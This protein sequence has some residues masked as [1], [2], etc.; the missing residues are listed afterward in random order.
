MVVSTKLEPKPK[1]NLPIK[2]KEG[3]TFFT[4]QLRNTPQWYKTW[5]R[6]RLKSHLPYVLRGC[7][8]KL[9]Q[10]GFIKRNRTAAEKG[11]SKNS[12][13]IPSG[14]PMVSVKGLNASETKD[15]RHWHEITP[16]SHQRKQRRKDILY[17]N[18]P[19][20]HPSVKHQIHP[21]DEPNR[22]E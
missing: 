15:K 20:F 12:G 2:Q 6:F 18:K 4:L 16:H 17:R 8:A 19:F 11:L 9:R 13:A 1:S 10:Y 21:P 14:K 22:K 5:F 7:R 3:V